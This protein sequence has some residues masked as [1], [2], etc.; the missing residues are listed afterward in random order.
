[1]F[2]GGRLKKV[3]KHRS[4]QHIDHGPETITFKDYRKKDGDYDFILYGTEDIN[5]R[6]EVLKILL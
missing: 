3:K 5:K 4:F 1:M 6:K 2:R